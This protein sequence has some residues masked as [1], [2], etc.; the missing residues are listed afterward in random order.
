MAVIS[1]TQDA[2]VVRIV[3]DGPPMAGK[4]TSLRTLAAKLGSEVQTPAEVDGRTL[5]FD[6]LDYTGGLFEGRRIRCQIVS[7]P[8]QASLASRRRAL[9]ETADA[10]V[11]VSDTTRDA[12]TQGRSYLHAARVALGTITGPTVGIVLQANKRDHA[13]AVPIS[14]LRAALDAPDEKVAIVESIATDGSGIREAF[15]FAVRLALD[16]VREIMKCSRLETTTPP[17][18]SAEAL[19]EDFE[20][21]EGGKL[22]LA[23][24]CGLQHTRL[25]VNA[26]T[27]TL[28]RADL[29]GG[30]IWPPVEGRLILHEATMTS[31]SLRQEGNGDWCGVDAP[32]WWIQSP[33]QGQFSDLSTARSAL[34]EWAR[35]HSAHAGLLGGRRCIALS[36]D[37][38]GNYRLWQCVSMSTTLRD[39]IEQALSLDVTSI[40]EALLESAR[41][42]VGARAQWQGSALT[43]R[44]DTISLTP[45]GPRYARPMP[46]PCG[47]EHGRTKDDLLTFL[48]GEFACVRDRL[49]ALRQEIGAAPALRAQPDPVATLIKLL[50]RA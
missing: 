17:I 49:F 8:G 13:D 16:R 41:A 28:P 42:L 38:A 30:M 35:A 6:W 34:V 37:G 19:L 40:V 1:S 22:E 32:G 15:V 18:D 48:R 36:D 47:I 23:A 12:V 39:H 9:L 27:P 44:I 33:A 26:E 45:T 11:F 14:E 5:Y 2:L 46:Y 20:R 10:V 21:R 29:P 43:A 4:T 7:V 31:P 24:S 3:Y 25:P 50:V